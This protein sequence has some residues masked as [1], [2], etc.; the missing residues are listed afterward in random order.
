VSDGEIGD[1]DSWDDAAHGWDDDPAVIAYAAAAHRS[2]VAVLDAR[3]HGIE[4]ARV[5]DF[6]CGTGLLTERLVTDGA[7]SVA[8][9]DT[10]EAML[11]V[12]DAKVAAHGWGNVDTADGISSSGTHYDL[13][14][15]SSVCSFLDDYPGTVADL[16]SLLA[17]GG[18]FV[19]WDWELD[20][21]DADGHGL[22]RT[23]IRDALEAAGLVDIHVDTAFRVAIDGAEMTPIVGIGSKPV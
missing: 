15:A 7:A 1:G 5:L 17:A 3:G 9:V 8:A 20:P 21:D 14:V 10:S 12:L 13:V 2:L 11:A 6:G 18:T 23:Q 16:A 4:A 19:Q 22:S